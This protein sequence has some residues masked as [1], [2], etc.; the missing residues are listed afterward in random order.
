MAEDHE[1][2]RDRRQTIAHGGRASTAM[3]STID[4]R[5]GR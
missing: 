2:D 1:E 4:S 3:S 5:R